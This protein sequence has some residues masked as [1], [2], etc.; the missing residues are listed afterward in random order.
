MFYSKYGVGVTTRSGGQIHPKKAHA[1]LR[2]P[3]MT[4]HIAAPLIPSPWNRPAASSFIGSAI[5]MTV[6]NWLRV[7]VVAMIKCTTARDRDDILVN[8]RG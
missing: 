6:R 5:A 7:P 8:Q 4:S 2:T 3:V 1:P